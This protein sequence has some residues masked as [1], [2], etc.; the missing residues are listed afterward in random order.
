MRVWLN[1]QKIAE[2][3]LTANDVVAAIREQNVQVAAGVIGASPTS[4]DVAMQLSVNAQG[5]LSTEE[6]FS[7]IVLKTS[8]D[9]GVT[10]LGDVARIELDASEYGLR[11]LRSE[12]HTSELQSLMRLSYAVFCLKKKKNIYETK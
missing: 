1:P 11:S 3:G 7:D 4:P 10:R 9:G 12:E 8:A 2:R 6:E 5:R